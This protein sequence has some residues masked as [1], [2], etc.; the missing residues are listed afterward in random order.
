MVLLTLFSYDD[1]QISI[2]KAGHCFERNQEQWIEVLVSWYMP[3]FIF[4]P[5]QPVI[6]N[7]IYHSSDIH[8]FWLWKWNCNV[9]VYR[10]RWRI[11]TS[12]SYLPHVICIFNCLTIAYADVSFLSTSW[13]KSFQRFTFNIF[14][15]HA[16]FAEE[17]LRV[18]SWTTIGYDAGSW[19]C[20]WQVFA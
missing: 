13:S 2:R 11:E 10:S 12:F 7:A 1:F 14:L 3:S 16:S 20:L 8:W 19:I 4:R 9:N 5:T 18:W 6:T 17:K 15:M